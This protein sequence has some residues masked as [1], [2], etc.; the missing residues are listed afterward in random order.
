MDY[1]LDDSRAGSIVGGLN[2]CQAPRYEAYMRFPLLLRNMDHTFS[3]N[4]DRDS[5]AKMY[6]SLVRSEGST[7]QVQ[8]LFPSLTRHKAAGN[9]ARRSTISASDSTDTR[10]SAYVDDSRR[11]SYGSRNGN[12]DRRG[13]SYAGSSSSYRDSPSEPDWDSETHNRDSRGARQPYSSRH[14]SSYIVQESFLQVRGHS[15]DVLRSSFGRKVESHDD[16]HSSRSNYGREQHSGNQQGL[17]RRAS[18]GKL[19]SGGDSN[20]IMRRYEV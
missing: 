14:S 2:M 1:F 6:Q 3:E 4:G 19:N 5:R 15:N 16:S 10:D 13:E 8:N 20:R 9:N 18:T 17:L 7:E 12:S 11:N